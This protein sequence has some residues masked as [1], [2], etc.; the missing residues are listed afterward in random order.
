MSGW[1]GVPFWNES[2]GGSG[3]GGGT[4][5]GTGNAGWP[6]LEGEI[7]VPVGGWYVRITEVPSSQDILY[8]PHGT[9]YLTS[10]KSIGSALL[11]A[12]AGLA[13]ASTALAGTYTAVVD[14]DYNDSTG[15]VTITASGV[16]SFTVD[17][18]ST[19]LRDALGFQEYLFGATSYTS[20]NSSPFLWLPDTFRMPALV[21]DGSPGLRVSDGTVVRSSSFTSKALQRSMGYVDRLEFSMVTGRRTR[22]EYEADVAVNASWTTFW[23]HSIGA[24]RHVRYHPHRTDDATYVGYRALSINDERVSPEVAS[25]TSSP[26]ALWR[27]GPMDV[28]NE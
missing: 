1:P 4:P 24:G 12:V 16:D 17:W 18:Q 27:V 26:E 21:P 19:A 6:K 10:A 2:P 7:R 23:E 8:I 20:P 15:R 11:S 22:P 5:G 14:D 9:A 28:V 3:G 13:N 25:W